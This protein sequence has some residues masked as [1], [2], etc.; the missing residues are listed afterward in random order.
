MLGRRRGVLGKGVKSVIG[1]RVF[2]L[3]QGVL[4]V[5]KGLIEGVGKNRDVPGL[6]LLFRAGCHFGQPLG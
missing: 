4:G 5:F 3:K 2:L 1:R 6:G